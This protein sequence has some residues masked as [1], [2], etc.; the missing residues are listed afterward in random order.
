MKRLLLFLLILQLTTYNL[1]LT[2]AMTATLEHVEKLFMEGRYEKAALEAKGFIDERSYRRDEIYY[3]K[4]LSELKLNRFREARESFESLLSRHSGSKR[5]FDAH[6]GIGDAY[7]LEGNTEEAIRSYNDT[8]AKF[9]NNK[10]VV[11]AY[12]RLGNCY[13]KKGPENKAIEY[14]EKVKKARLSFESRMIAD[15]KGP[16][17]IASP[18]MASIAPSGQGNNGNFSVQ[19]GSFKSKKNANRLSAKLSSEGYDSRVEISTGSGDAFYRVRIGRY[20]SKRSA[21]DAAGV[22]R[23]AGYNT[24][25]SADDICG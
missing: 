24:K 12:Y 22:L 16:D 5:N 13:R 7:F 11:S 19:V 4:G 20:K 25:V 6:L 23:R 9:P 18:G 21:E 10:N 15:Y 17:R 1:Q 2:Y 8:V 3:L 14:F